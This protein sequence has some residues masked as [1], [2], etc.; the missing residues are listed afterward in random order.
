MKT[1]IM[2]T[3]SKFLYVSFIDDNKVIFNK[4]FEAKNNHSENLLNTIKIGLQENKLEVKD[5][6]K[7]IIGIGPGSYTGLRVSTTIGKMFAWSLNIPLYTISSL[8]II[9]SGYFN[10]DGV[11]ALTSIAKRDYLYTKIVEIN[12]GKYNVIENDNFILAEDFNKKIESKGYSVIDESNFL[13]DGQKIIELANA[14]VEDIH[15]LVPN[16]LRKANT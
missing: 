12:N 15:N 9:G 1:M 4:I 14:K 10:K 11:Y 16:Y 2:D 7:I 13:F 6:N 3:S 5:F 8:D